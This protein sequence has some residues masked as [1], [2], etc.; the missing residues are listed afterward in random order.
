M[1]DRTYTSYSLT[2]KNS[3]PTQKGLGRILSGA[4]T[5]S[6]QCLLYEDTENKV[7]EGLLVLI[8]ARHG[9][10]LSRIEAIIPYHEYYKVPSAWDEAIRHRSRIPEEVARKGITAEL[11][12]LGVLTPKGLAEVS[13]PPNPGD[14]VLAL[15]EEGEEYEKIFGVRRE[16]PGYIWFGTILGYDNLP[17]PLNVENITMH[18][19][20]TGVT[21]SGK[22]FT[23]G[24]LIELI[25]NIPF[26]EDKQKGRAALPTI[27]IDANEDY[28]DYAISFYRGEWETA[29]KDL[30]VFVS[31][32][33]TVPIRYPLI[34]T[35]KI[36]IDLNAFSP[37]E[38]AEL[39][40]TY[41]SGGTLNELQVAG[42]ESVLKELIEEED[43]L[44][45][46]IFT[47]HTDELYE[48]LEEAK[49]RNL[50]YHTTAKAIH[51]AVYKFCEDVVRGQKI[52]S[53]RPIISPGFIDKITE[54]PS[55]VL[56]DFSADGCPM[57]PLGVKQLIVAYLAK[58]LY[59]KFTEYKIERKE[60]YLMFM[61][62]EAQNYCPNLST[63]PIG[64]SLAREYISLIA[65]QGRKFGLILCLIAQRP[66]FVDPIVLSMVGTFI[67][68]RISPEDI[69]FVRKVTGGLP[70]VL[71][72]KLTNLQRGT[73]II[74]G[75]MNSLGFPIL[76]KVKGRKIPHT[77]GKTEV[78]R[79]LSRP[80]L[81]EV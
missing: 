45:S 65:T 20:N 55:L 10:I 48:K 54:Q 62:E 67:I 70:K 32:K 8:D 57:M 15:S 17:I 59:N 41:Y 39:V 80:Y 40:I 36:S 61:I 49:S 13:S 24:Y 56:I 2:Y 43:Y 26:E 34:R 21:G 38:L 68:H 9:R 58:L 72:T 5:T 76:V 66:S 6:A 3:M 31:E 12:L 78:M 19:F 53:D 23:A 74:T 71:E 44:P 75:Q 30:Y 52:V 47:R 79:A 14:E 50:I 29:Y 16:S 1:N 7:Q 60:R 11:S 51:R 35:E 69:S 33:S 73:A 27:I 77:M 81:K 63:Y 18:M 37:R 22:S 4:T 64:Y 25:S 42:L 28:L 46:E